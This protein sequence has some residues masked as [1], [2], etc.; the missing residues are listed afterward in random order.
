M[1]GT[2]VQS[3]VQESLTCHRATKPV[4]HN[5]RAQA[6]QQEKPQQWEACALQ[7]ESSPCLPS[8]EEANEQ[9]CRPS[10]V[11]NKLGEKKKKNLKKSGVNGW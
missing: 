11:K 5:S 1:Q 6:P 8:L 4:W 3:L 9:Q 10:A 7:L 2:R